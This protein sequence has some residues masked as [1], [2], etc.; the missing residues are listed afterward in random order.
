M[1][2]IQITDWKQKG[3]EL[4]K[5]ISDAVDS[6][7]KKQFV[8]VPSKIIMNRKQYNS[9]VEDDL[10]IPMFDPGV[11]KS[12]IIYNDRVRAAEEQL[13]LTKGGYPLEVEVNDIPKVEDHA[14]ETH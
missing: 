10:F 6:E 5:E 2:E 13:F 11:S 9:M 8:E 4:V 12:G 14:T 3:Q 7:S 1:R